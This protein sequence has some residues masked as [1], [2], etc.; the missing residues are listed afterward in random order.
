MPNRGDPNAPPSPPV[1]ILPPDDWRWTWVESTLRRIEQAAIEDYSRHCA[2]QEKQHS[3]CSVA[4]PTNGY[5]FDE[6]K[7]F[8]PP[9]PTCHPLHPRP[10]ASQVLFEFNS[11]ESMC[12][13][14]SSKKSEAEATAA[15][16]A[17]APRLDGPPYELLLLDST[18][19]N[20]FS[21]GFGRVAGIVVYSGE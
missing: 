18:E 10:R 2:L 1:A 7:P 17:L 9:P 11:C 14:G 3:K 20:A 13:P 6:S 21:H 15:P 4:G 19:Q 12:W 8:P 5:T 16:A